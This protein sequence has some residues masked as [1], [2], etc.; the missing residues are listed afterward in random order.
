MEHKPVDG[1]G[2]HFQP[3]AVLNRQVLLL[4]SDRDGWKIHG[5]NRQQKGFNQFRKAFI[6]ML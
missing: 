3:A 5:Y 6:R 2:R 4:L 1:P